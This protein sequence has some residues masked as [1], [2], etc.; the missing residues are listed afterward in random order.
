[1]GWIRGIGAAKLVARPS[2]D[3]L[4]TP[5]QIKGSIEHVEDIGSTD[6]D[7]ISTDRRVT[8]NKGAKYPFQTSECVH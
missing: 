3:I 8:P 1:M 5:W 4:T 2:Q 6:D 7:N